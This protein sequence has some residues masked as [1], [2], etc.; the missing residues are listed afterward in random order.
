[1]ADH[2]KRWIVTYFACVLLAIAFTAWGNI[3]LGSIF[4]RLDSRGWAAVVG[5]LVFLTIKFSA[6]AMHKREYRPYEQGYEASI[7]AA[8][9]AIPAAAV[10]YHIRDSRSADWMLY[11]ALSLV[12]MFVSSA[13][14]RAAEES[15][16]DS[17]GQAT[18]GL[19]WWTLAN[20]ILGTIVFLFYVF[21]LIKKAQQ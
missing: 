3:A 17:N 1:M 9:A 13:V 12:T 14:V 4:P 2:A 7:I 10:S 6:S 11:A 18:A 16:Y 20:Y 5:A 19:V 15:G 8:G 21:L